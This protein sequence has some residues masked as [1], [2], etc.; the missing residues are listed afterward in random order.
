MSLKDRMVRQAQNAKILVLH[1]EPKKIL[2]LVIF[3]RASSKMG[4]E[5]WSLLIALL[6]SLGSIQRRSF[7]GL[8]TAT[9]MLIHLVVC[10]LYF[11]GH[12]YILSYEGLK[13]CLQFTFH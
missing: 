1:Q 8:L 12:S 10:F 13:I 9:V 2:A 3:G 5:W 4:K 7:L 11:F 6:G